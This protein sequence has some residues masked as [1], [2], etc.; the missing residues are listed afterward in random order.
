[1]RRRWRIRESWQTADAG[2]RRRSE[3]KVGGWPAG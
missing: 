3:K 1:M 2:R